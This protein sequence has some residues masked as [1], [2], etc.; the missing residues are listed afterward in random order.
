MASLGRHAVPNQSVFQYESV[1]QC[2]LSCR[3]G[4][5][6]LLNEGVVQGLH[7]LHEVSYYALLCAEVTVDDEPYDELQTMYRTWC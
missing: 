6:R 5:V 1:P 4:E 3:R 7:L 2:G